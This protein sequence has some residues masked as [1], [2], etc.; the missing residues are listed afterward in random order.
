MH[1]PGLPQPTLLWIC[2]ERVEK[3]YTA[4]GLWLLFDFVTFPKDDARRICV[5]E[6][7]IHI[8]SI[9]DACE[10]P[11][12][13]PVMKIVTAALVVACLRVVWTSLKRGTV[14]NAA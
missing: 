6:Q 1:P 9:L 8:A 7:T 14:K 3:A 5:T 13:G 12:L 11:M 10:C 4:F 2:S